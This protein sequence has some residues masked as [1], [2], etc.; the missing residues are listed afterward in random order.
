MIIISSLFKKNINLLKGVGE[1][2]AIAFRKL[3]IQSIGDLFYY[4]PRTFE[5]LSKIYSINEAPLD[6]NCCIKATV[7][8]QVSKNFLK[9]GMTTYKVKVSD[10]FST[11]TV[12]FFNN[13][14]ISNKLKLNSQ[15]YFWGKVHNFSGSKVMSSP[16]IYN[17][18]EV[19]RL[20]P[21][22]QQTEN[23]SSKQ[24]E[25]AIKQAFLLL[26]EEFPDTLPENVRSSYKL[27]DLKFALQN[28]HF[29]KNSNNLNKAKKRLIFEEFLILNL[30]F[31]KIKSDKNSKNAF[32]LKKNHLPE[33]LE[34][35]P[36]TLTSAQ[37]KTI[38]ECMGD[39]KSG[40]VMNRLIQGDVGCGKTV[41]AAALAF[42]IVKENA[43]VAFMAPTE[44]LAQQHFSYLK[45][46]F[47]KSQISVSI[48]L[49]C[50]STPKKQKNLIKDNLM[51][52]NIDI[53]IGTHALLE[54]NVLFKNLGLVITDEQHRFGVNQRKTLISKGFNPHTIIMS[55]TPI[56]RSLAL[57]IYGDLDI[58]AIN[59]MPK[60]KQPIDTYLIDQQKRDRALSFIKKLVDEGRQAYI[61]CP[62]IEESE[63]LQV[64]SAIEYFEN[65]KTSSVL[66]DYSIGLL[67]GKMKPYEKNE[68]MQLFIDKKIDIL[69]S[70][71][72]IEVGIDVK[73]ASI[74]M[75]ENAERLGLSQIHQ[76]RGRVG[77]GEFKSFCILVSDKLNDDA[78][79][80]KLNIIVQNNDGFK[81]ADNDL[82][83]RGPGDFLGTK[84]HGFLK[85]KSIKL[86]N[87][88]GILNDVK[89]AA[90]SIL[91]ED[92]NLQKN[93]NRFLS[94]AV[95]NLFLIN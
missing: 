8:S 12:T 62:I 1:K 14:Y 55:A 20:H 29:P 73:N 36:F 74:M 28:I 51:F 23:L 3:G 88:L 47:S 5:D 10:G 45:N 68:I 57:I 32:T 83:I 50:G 26:P 95:S 92:P 63:T 33:F 39:M 79:R 58:S 37:L 41:V 13:K 16:K 91:K 70:T 7:I 30:S 27:C 22:Y 66:K 77:R 49:L 56:P 31:N 48:E 11:M 61:V 17:N 94:S 44:I 82:E 25:S 53:I 84:Q 64:A 21:I 2:R 46:L 6:E 42:N 80:K 60:F 90:T 87:D 19:N 43:Q 78:I 52:G 89:S 72:V 34:L 93:E 65:L 86:L 71:T 38:N 18:D 4:F 85:L 24:I 75:I 35:L 15:H 40:K 9:K 69:V 54:D 59:E 76:L 67:H 81:I